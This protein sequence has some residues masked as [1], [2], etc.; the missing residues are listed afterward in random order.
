MWR[1]I[2]STSSV[3]SSNKV[4]LLQLET[5]QA[6]DIVSPLWC[7]QMED[8]SK[9]C[10]KSS[11]LTS[12][13][14][15]VIKTTQ[16]EQKVKTTCHQIKKPFLYPFPFNDHVEPLECFPNIW[17]QTT[18]VPELLD[19]AKYWRKLRPSEQSA[20]TIRWRFQNKNWGM[21]ISSNDPIGHFYIQP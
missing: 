19:G 12:S 7:Q 15:E 5:S 21:L 3:K 13:P 16:H 9:H 14:T 2:E 11:H 1:L 8:G 18:Q 20:R 10:I 6:T 4:R 17:I